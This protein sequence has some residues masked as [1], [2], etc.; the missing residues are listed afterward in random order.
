MEDL[1]LGAYISMTASI[2][3]ISI[4]HH[5]SLM[6]GSNP[7]WRLLLKLLIPGWTSSSSSRETGN[8]SADR[9]ERVICM[10]LDP[11]L[12]TWGVGQILAEN[13]GK[14]RL[15]TRQSSHI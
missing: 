1:T 9:R 4:L 11:K 5:N 13:K 7:A 3:V 15:Q 10:A 8:L 12:V 14:V 2:E 6:S